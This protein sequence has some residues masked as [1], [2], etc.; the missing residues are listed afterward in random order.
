MQRH[1]VFENDFS[2]TPWGQWCFQDSVLE[3]VIMATKE[4]SFIVPER[5]LGKVDIEF[6]VSDETGKIGE[7]RVSKGAVVWKP[8]NGKKGY[9]IGWRRLGELLEQHG[10]FGHQ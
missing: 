5:P 8:A 2:L 7:L 9:K 10:K 1:A 3:I 6:F 4:V